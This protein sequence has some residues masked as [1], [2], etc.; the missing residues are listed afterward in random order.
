M[1]FTYFS[2]TKLIFIFSIDA[3]WKFDS[4]TNK[5]KNKKGYTLNGEFKQPEAGP[6]FIEAKS[7]NKVLGFEGTEEHIEIKLE[8]KKTGANMANQMWKFS[9]INN[10]PATEG[11]FTIES[12]STKMLLHGDSKGKAFLGSEFFHLKY[13][14]DTEDDGKLITSRKSIRVEKRT[15][16]SV[17]SF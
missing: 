1:A 3:L 5:F 6:G 12:V 13:D 10:L 7:G 9:Q 4:A 15:L 2:K 17:F 11:F 16:N 14:Y 8:D